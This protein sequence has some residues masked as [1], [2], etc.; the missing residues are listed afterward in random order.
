[1]QQ[2]SLHHS[3]L[4]AITLSIKLL[5]LAFKLMLY[6]CLIHSYL[7]A[8]LNG[9]I[10]CEIGRFPAFSSKEQYPS[11]PGG[12]V[13][14]LTYLFPSDITRESCHPNEKIRKVFMVISWNE[15]IESEIR[16]RFLRIKQ[17]LQ[18]KDPVGHRISCRISQLSNR[19]RAKR[20]GES[21][22]VLNYRSTK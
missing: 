13:F 1:M 14:C 2:S 8:L 15:K 4:V 17:T 22:T 6:H 11:P 18:D 10:S 7:K 12:L 5:M 21:R 16:I 3:S 19:L 9:S 20:T